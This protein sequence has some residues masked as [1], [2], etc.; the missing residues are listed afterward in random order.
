MTDSTEN[1][2]KPARV[3]FPEDEAAHPWLSLLLDAYLIFDEGVNE[4]IQREEKKGRILACKKGCSACCRTHTSIPVYP[5]EL[6]GMTWHATEKVKNPKRK[7]LAGQLKN[8]KDSKI[9]PFLASDICSI[10]PLRPAACRHFNVFDRACGEGED[11]Y[12]TRR[13]D[14]LTPIQKYMDK[15][16]NVMLPFYGAANRAKRRQVLKSGAIHTKAMP[17]LRCNWQSL[18]DKMEEYEKQHPEAFK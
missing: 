18:P 3:S 16:F 2:N 11:A 5:L 14:V 6:V 7:K 9:C 8:Y 17:M 1:N 4:A 13:G 10:Y 15:A 12:Y